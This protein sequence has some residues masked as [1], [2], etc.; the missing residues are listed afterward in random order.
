MRPTKRHVAAGA[1]GLALLAAGGGAYA[2]TRQ[3]S[4]DRQAFLNDA[5][6]RLHV[7]PQQLENALR[8]A[9]LDRLD[10]AVKAGRLTQQ[11]AD[12][13]KRRLQSG[14]GLGLG[15]GHL[16]R[17]HGRFE[18]RAGLDAAAAYLGLTDVELRNQLTAGKSL[19]D[20]AGARGKTVS[21]LEAA[22]I[23]PVRKRLDTA[24]KA[25][26]ITQAQEQ[27]FLARIQ[28]RVAALVQRPGLRRP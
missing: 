19:A 8:G 28:Q 14:H 3:G 26:R 21:G 1:T 16:F 5:A 22:L 15:A 24:V 2:A 18:H 13:I 4:N 9:A 20:I 10:A 27:R 25:G 23:A 12:A 11:Q 7:T 17:H 6:R